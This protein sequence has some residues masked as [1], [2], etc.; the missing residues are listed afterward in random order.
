M[1][2]L[3]RALRGKPVELSPKQQAKYDAQMAKA[4][5]IIAEQEAKGAAALEAAAPWRPE[6][7]PAAPPLTPSG[8]PDIKAMLKDSLEQAKDS[9]GEMFDDRAGII[10]RP[11]G[12]DMNRPP[13]Q[14]DDAAERERVAAAER[15]ARDAARAPFRAEVV[16]QVAT[17]R[18][19]TTGQRQFEDVADALR[20]SGL[21]SAPERVYGVHRLPERFDNSKRGSEG[22][23]YVE[24]EIVYALGP[25]RA[26][27]TDEVVVT[28]FRR[29][30]HWVARAPGEASVTDEDLAGTFCAAARLRPEDCFGVPRLVHVRGVQFSEAGTSWQ[31]DVDGTAVIHRAVESAREVQEQLAADAPLALANPPAVPF[32]VEVLDWEAVA[33]WVA[34]SRWEAPRVPSPLP[35][36]PSSWEELLLMYLEVVGVRSADSYGIA[37][38]RTDEGLLADLSLASARQNFR[39]PTKSR[40]A[41]GKDRTTMHAAQHL[42]VTYRDR[43]EYADGRARWQAYQRDVLDAHLDHLTGAHPPLQG[44]ANPRPSFLS[45]VFDFVNPLDPLQ[46]FPQLIGRGDYG[47]LGPYVGP[48]PKPEGS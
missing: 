14:I 19:S 10:G 3:I 13:A 27:S 20:S 45:E 12:T 11:E 24:W 2:N 40:C 43:P 30:A 25:A 47:L 44:E 29:D 31:A 9:F 37:A 26:P 5:R 33:A 36:L 39:G 42:V 6:G 15:A 17:L 41:D 23:V 38:T 16:P 28:A 48:M 35:H 4:Q 34:P 21:A 22:R 7:T 46:L 8:R 1:R 32:F 18:V